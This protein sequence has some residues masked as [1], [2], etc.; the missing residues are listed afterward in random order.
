MFSYFKK[1]SLF[2]NEFMNALMINITKTLLIAIC[3]VFCWACGNENRNNFYIEGTTAADDSSKV[4]YMRLYKDTTLIDSATV[5]NHRFVFEGRID[6]AVAV[7]VNNGDPHNGWMFFLE[8][9]SLTLCDSLYYAEGGQLN[10]EYRRFIDESDNENDNED[11]DAYVSTV[12]KYWAKH[13][14]DAF[15]A[16]MLSLG[17]YYMD[18]DEMEALANNAGENIKDDVLLKMVKKN[19]ALQKKTSAGQMFSDATLKDLEGNTHTLSEYIGKGKYVIMDCW[20]SWCPPCR[21]LIPELKE[22]YAQYRSK[23]VEVIGVA[24]RDEAEDTKK[25]V[26]ELDIPWTVLTDCCMATTIR[27]VYGFEGIPFV[28]M[29]APDGTIIKRDLTE[30]IIKEILSDK[31][32]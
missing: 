17:Y 26:E 19:I 3:A 31:F 22:I 4:V 12:K 29:F 20:A 5:E 1:K 32:K 25:A 23:G 16:Y 27:D 14:D 13:T 11:I 24:T 8:K 7:T 21:R 30:T 28:I 9:D 6:R 18:C 2:C 15:G 10:R